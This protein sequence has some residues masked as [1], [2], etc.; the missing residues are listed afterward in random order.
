[1]IFPFA[2]FFFSGCIIKKVR[3]HKKIPKSGFSLES[4]KKKEEKRRDDEKKLL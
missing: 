3:E 2:F 4:S 1:M